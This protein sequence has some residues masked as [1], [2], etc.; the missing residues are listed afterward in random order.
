[1]IDGAWRSD[2]MELATGDRIG[3]GGL[4]IETNQNESKQNKIKG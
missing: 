4:A 3:G 2:K 1:M